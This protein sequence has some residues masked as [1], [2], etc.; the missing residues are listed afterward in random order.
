MTKAERTRLGL[1]GAALELF[2]ERGYE[3]TTV[4]MIAARAGVS[5]M[6]FFRYFRSKDAVLI[7]DPYDPLIAQAISRQP[8]E[9]APLA[10]AIGGIAESWRAIP[11]PA[12]NEVRERLRIVSGTPSLRGAIGRNNATTEEAI[13]GALMDRGASRAEAL[14][15]AAAVI[16]ALNAALLDWADGDDPDL[17]TA[18]GTALRVLRGQSQ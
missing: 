5:E 13:A 7:D 2:V 4:A 17:D 3:A 11:A 14:I 16:S 8:A 12:S 6:T 9:L 1:M 10:A 15:A 18:I